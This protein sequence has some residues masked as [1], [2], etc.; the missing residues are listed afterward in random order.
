MSPYLKYIS[1]IFKSDLFLPTLLFVTYIGF[2][3]VLKGV[4]PS[5]DE[6]VDTFANLYAKYGYEIIFF[7][8]LLESL[9][10]V[11]FLVPGQIGMA[12]GVIF[13]RSGQTELPLVILFVTLGTFMGYTI[14][15]ILGYYGFS[16]LIKRFGY[17][18]LIDKGKD[19]IS[20]FGKRGLVLSYIHSTLGAFSSLA[21]GMIKMNY[22]AVL[23]I[24]LFA[25]LFWAIL[26]SILIYILGDVFLVIFR[27]YTFILFLIFV[28]F[29]F[30]AR[31]WK[32][33]GK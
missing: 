29:L 2:I 24:A 22:I 13:A 23:A 4:F 3:F 32:E 6:L 9:I 11:N 7:S 20:K 5:G 31:F 8:A 27:K 15:Y 25:T 18:N 26:W 21:A 30:L 1:T 28:T 17:S 14:D 33:K 12:L 10:L 16:D 19:Q